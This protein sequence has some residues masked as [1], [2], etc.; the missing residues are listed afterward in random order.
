M[1]CADGHACK[2]VAMVKKENV[3]F[4]KF[5]LAFCRFILGLIPSNRILIS[6]FL[7]RSFSSFIARTGRTTFLF[8][9]LILI[10]LVYS[11]GLTM[12][13]T[14]VISKNGLIR[15]YILSSAAFECKIQ[16]SL[17]RRAS[18]A[19]VFQAATMNGAVFKDLKAKKETFLHTRRHMLKTSGDLA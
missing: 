15:L 18:L 17:L 8:Y 3:M 11:F 13:F 10:F 2:R 19:C 5:W 14:D 4:M 16:R 9:Y 7:K 1:V 6:F 12:I